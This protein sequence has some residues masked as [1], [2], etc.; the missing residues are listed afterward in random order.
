MLNKIWHNI[1]TMTHFEPSNTAVLYYWP[2]QLPVP[3]PGM[4]QDLMSNLQAVN[5][6]LLL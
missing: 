6:Q 1:L 5:G 2:F 4:T 3:M